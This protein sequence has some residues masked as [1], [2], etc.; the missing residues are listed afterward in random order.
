MCKLNEQHEDEVTLLSDSAKEIP[1]NELQE[2]KAD[3]DS[4]MEVE[5]RMNSNLAQSEEQEKTEEV[6]NGAETGDTQLSRSLRSK[7]QLLRVLGRGSF[8]AIGLAILMVG[9]VASNY[10][11]YYVD[12]GEY[13][14]CSTA[15]LNEII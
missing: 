14:N 9:G 15:Q 1:L 2:I 5:T 13:E 10:Q 11:P 3:M 8:F 12:P 4:I 7:S 6:R